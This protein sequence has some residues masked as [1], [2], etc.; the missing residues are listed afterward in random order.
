[1]RQRTSRPEKTDARK[2]FQKYKKE[3]TA[4]TRPMQATK[5]SVMKLLEAWRDFDFHD[6]GG[7]IDANLAAG[8]EKALEAVKDLRYSAEDVEI[9]SRMLADIRTPNTDAGL[10]LTALVNSGPDSGY[11][12][13]AHGEAEMGIGHQNTKDLER[14]C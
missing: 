4:V 14:R 5:P 12:V 8:Y 7:W 10:F 13:H 11:T 6:D 9:F 2:K 3:E 1:M